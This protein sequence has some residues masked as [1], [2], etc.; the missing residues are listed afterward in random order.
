MAF[1]NER[2]L[3]RLARAEH[4][5]ALPNADGAGRAGSPRRGRVVCIYLHVPGESILSA[6]FEAFGSAGVIAAA[7]AA[8][9]LLPGL[10]PAQALA[11][12]GREIARAAGG[13]PP[14]REQEASL[15][16]DAVKAAVIDLCRRRGLELEYSALPSGGCRGCAGGCSGCGK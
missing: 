1:Y 7:E 3:A 13:L 9:E 6:S 14:G 5:G 11:L 16:E 2:I 8:A 4:A 12:S 10:T 15:A